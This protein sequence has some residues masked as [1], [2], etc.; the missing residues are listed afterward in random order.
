[1]A[2]TILLVEDDAVAQAAMKRALTEAGYKVDTASS[3]YEAYEKLGQSP[4]PY[5]AILSD[6]NLGKRN[7]TGLEV[8]QATR[9]YRLKGVFIGSSSKMDKWQQVVDHGDDPN[10]H[11]IAKLDYLWNHAA[12]LAKL[13]ELG[14]TP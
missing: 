13:T 10:F 7:Q 4:L 12:I 11:A 1:M 6:Y 14:I 3:I 9:A 5:A 8:W 2:K